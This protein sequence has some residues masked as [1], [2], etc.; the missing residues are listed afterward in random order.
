ML[1]LC[2]KQKLYKIQISL[3]VNKFYWKHGHA[4]PCMG[5]LWLLPHYGRCNRAY[6]A[7]AEILTIWLRKSLLIPDMDEEVL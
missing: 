3:S 7:K 1:Q 6:R 2:F 5:R 4:H